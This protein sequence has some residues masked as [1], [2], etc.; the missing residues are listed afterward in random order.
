MATYQ[1]RCVQDGDFEV[2]RPIGMAAPQVR[3]AACGADAVRVF[4]SP[5]LS[6]A[7]RAIVAA[8]DRSERTRDQPAMVSSLPPGRVANSRRRHVLNLR[9]SR[10]RDPDR[11][12]IAFTAPHLAHGLE[13]GP[14]NGGFAPGRNHELHRGC[15]QA[16]RLACILC[17]V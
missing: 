2:S 6:L 16:I 12:L 4:T 13:T 9:F 3:C 8:I 5:M 17:I 10:F 7:S 15:E 1:H 14:R 11:T